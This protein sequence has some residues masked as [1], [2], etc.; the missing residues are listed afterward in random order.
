MKRQRV[1]PYVRVGVV[2]FALLA[3]GC[4]SGTGGAGLVSTSE[5]SGFIA[6]FAREVLAAFLL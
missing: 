5:L 4:T 1:V 3:A 6:D 2:A